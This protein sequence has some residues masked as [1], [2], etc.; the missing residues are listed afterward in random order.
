MPKAI[1]HA[2]E[3]RLLERARQHMVKHADEGGLELRQNYS[4]VS[5][6][7]EYS[8]LGKFKPA[9]TRRGNAPGSA[10]RRARRTQSSSGT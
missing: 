8:A 10:D 4:G 2:T 7:D 1:A 6:A 9:L 5:P 3:T